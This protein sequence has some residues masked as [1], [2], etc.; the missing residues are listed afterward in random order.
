[1]MQFLFPMVDC[2]VENGN[3]FFLGST[4]GRENKF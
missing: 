2:F 4:K 3:Y 1:M